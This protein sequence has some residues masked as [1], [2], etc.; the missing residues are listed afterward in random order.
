MVQEALCV[1]GGLYVCS[2]V[3]PTFIYASMHVSRQKHLQPAWL[4]LT[5]T[6]NGCFYSTPDNR[7]KYSDQRVFLSVCVCVC[8]CLSARDYIF[9]TTRLMFRKFFVH[10]IYGCGPLL[11]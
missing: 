2:Q 6:F 10:V 5:A 3:A 9:G 1:S 8:V 4:A 7:V 11:F